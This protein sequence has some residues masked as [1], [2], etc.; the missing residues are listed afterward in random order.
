MNTLF[1][2]LLIIKKLEYYMHILMSRICLFILLLIIK[3]VGIFYAHFDVTYLLQWL[4]QRK[5]W[6]IA[7]H[8]CT[9]KIQAYDCCIP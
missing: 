5:S 4:I 8:P 1:I 3:K 2:L 6:K 9:V 7:N